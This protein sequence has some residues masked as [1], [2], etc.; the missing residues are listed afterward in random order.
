MCLSMM[1]NAMRMLVLYDGISITSTT[2]RTS[3]A[4]GQQCTSIFNIT[5]EY[6]MSGSVH[7]GLACT[8][9]A[10]YI[11]GTYLCG[12]SQFGSSTCSNISGPP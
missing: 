4:N 10:V 1:L 6:E 7:G 9:G 5:H 8:S 2:I 11:T 12:E 3:L